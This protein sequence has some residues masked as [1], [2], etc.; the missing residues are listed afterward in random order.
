[1]VQ[2]TC[3]QLNRHLSVQ[4]F[5]ASL[6]QSY[7][8]HVTET[9]IKSLSLLDDFDWSIF[10]SGR[11]LVREGQ[12]KLQF[13]DK[14]G[15]KVSSCSTNIENRFWWQLPAG[16]LADKLSELVSVRAFVEKYSCQLKT[17]HLNIL[18][19]DAKIVLRVE[20]YTIIDLGSQSYS[21]IRSFPLR[22]YHKEYLQIKNNLK[23]SISADFPAI[24][25]SRFLRQTNLNINPQNKKIIFQLQGIEPAEVAVSKMAVKMIQLARHQEQ[26]IIDDIDTEFVHQYRV[27]IRKTRSLISLFK[28]S[29]SQ[30]RYQLY[31]TVLKALGNQSN[32]LRDLD[33][34]LL[35]YD[36]YRNML[37]ENLWPGLEH[38]FKRIKLRRAAALKK[39]VNS[40]TEESYS[41]KIGHLLV[42][43]QQEP[44]LT[45]KQSSIKIRSLA[46]KKIL[47]Q[48]QK[49]C[50]NGIA[51]TTDTPDGPVHDLR[52][53]CKKLRYLLELF[54][55][56]YS[57]NQ[58]KKLIK[59]LKALQDNLGRFNDFSVQRNFLLQLAQGKNIS[60]EQLA[61]IYGLTAVLHYKQSHERNLVMANIATFS[62]S[63]VEG[64]L[65]LLL[66]VDTIKDSKV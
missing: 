12:D 39:M 7:A 2:Q 15:N 57:A 45:A 6:P 29:F 50:A 23:S 35:D 49:I 42:T 37:P 13:L 31:K 66:N 3:W 60:A 53:E 27:N 30:N 52:I 1:M 17:E 9:T 38:L 47:D 8:L 51:I 55:E 14:N 21:F 44:E 25:L 28:K 40:L 34:F 61:S 56:L 24:D 58:V 11:I 18:N 65:K 33:V 41:E 10:H 20:F 4:D 19:A 43:L 32:S 59:H 16:E 5:S 63:A 64:Q 46:G 54:A 48:Y 36:Y 22:G 62:A 26:G